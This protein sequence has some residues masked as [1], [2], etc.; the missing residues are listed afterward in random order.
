MQ[1][2]AVAGVLAALATSLAAAAPGSGAGLLST[3]VSVPDA[4]ARDC[5][6]KL[7]ESG[8][9]WSGRSSSSAA[10]AATPS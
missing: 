10:S 5:R 4:V 1:R 7:L 6:A 2:V 3:F 9:R 8:T